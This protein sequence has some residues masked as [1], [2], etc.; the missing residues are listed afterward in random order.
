MEPAETCSGVSIVEAWSRAAQIVLA[1]APTPYVLTVTSGIGWPAASHEIW[2]LDAAAKSVGAEKPSTVAEMLLPGAAKQSTGNAAEAIEAGLRMLGRGRRK[3]LTF[4]GWG[5]TYFERLVGAFYDR[6]EVK[7]TFGQN[8]LLGVIT[9]LNDW[10]ANAE[11]VFYIHTNLPGDN[12]RK[13]GSPCLQYVQFRAHAGMRL[14]IVGLYRAHDYTN[15]FL[16]NALGIQSVA[17]FVARHTGR[18]YDGQTIISLH[19]F[20]EKKA[21]LGK[22]IDAAVA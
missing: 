9:K 5:H 14:S 22:L 1:P 13:R 4:S 10:G 12:F 6:N 7:N 8:R 15:K 20:C 11:A 2:K 16:G 18:Q 21:Q 17:Q 3:G 19:P